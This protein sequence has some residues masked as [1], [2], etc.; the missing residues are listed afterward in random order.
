LHAQSEQDGTLAALS[1]FLFE[2]V[3]VLNDPKQ[4]TSRAA[5]LGATYGKLQATLSHSID[6]T[7]TH[8]YALQEATL[9][10]LR[11]FESF[12]E[13]HRALVRRWFAEGTRNAARS[14]AD[15]MQEQAQEEREL[16]ERFVL[17]I[18][19]DLRNPLTSIRTYAGIINRFPNRIERN[20]DLAGRIMAGVDRL[21]R[22]VS[23]IH[24]THLIRAGMP[25]ELELR[26]TD[27]ESVIRSVVDSLSVS[28]GDRFVI[29][30]SGNLAGYWC[31]DALERVLENFLT[32][33]LKYGHPTAP[34][35]IAA[36]P[37]SEGGSNNFEFSVHN[38]G[39]PI[40][41]AEQATLFQLFKRST[42]ARRTGK[43]GWGIGLALVRVLIEAHGG[44]IRLESVPERGTTFYVRLPRE[45]RLIESK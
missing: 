33:A 15:W 27:F 6:E 24:D 7:L 45:T 16:R 1:Q 21:D 32:N 28:H 12:D 8:F 18:A 22:M 30:L 9:E 13:S 17:S 41:L 35:V 44:E 29:H 2:L 31:P 11:L 40:P 36:G 10:A 20:G 37:S 42:N 4:G 38:Q 3:S 23:N 19:H 14:L 34:I 25:I 39:D 26:E 43:P 5:E